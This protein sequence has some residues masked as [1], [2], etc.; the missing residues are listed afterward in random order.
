VQPVQDRFQECIGCWHPRRGA[1]RSPLRRDPQYDVGLVER[2]LG[3]TIG[4]KK[5]ATYEPA[6]AYEEYFSEGGLYRNEGK[7][8]ASARR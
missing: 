7:G 1:R 6:Q 3:V 4:D 5:P 8:S 2:V